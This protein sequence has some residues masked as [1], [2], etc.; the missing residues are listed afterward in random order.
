MAS[1][2]PDRLAGTLDRGLAILSH[3][4]RH[5]SSRVPDIAAA[6]GLSRPTIYRL[7]ERLRQQG[8]LIQEGHGGEVR[9][10]PAAAQLAAAAMESTTLRDAA[11][12]ALSELLT[13]TRE[14]VSL[15][16]PNGLAMVFVHRAKG[17]H[18]VGVSAELGVTRPLHCTSVGRAYLAA[19]PD[20]QCEQVLDELVASGTSPVQ[21][22][23]LPALRAILAETRTRGWAQD[24]REFNISSSC[25][26]AEIRD[27]T[28]QPIAA[29]SVAGVAERM[30][31]E[32]DHIGPL[33]RKAADSVSARLGYL[34]PATG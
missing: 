18:P 26:G 14:T 13:A 32:L 17:P 4:A 3:L 21:A 11:D 23:D 10:G 2:R 1:D 5:R 16:V 9:L 31:S 30:D 25:A 29:I 34:P 6:L 28:G 20:D 19:L 27:Y 22:A 33:V 12:L 8:W 24:R 7:I 15:A